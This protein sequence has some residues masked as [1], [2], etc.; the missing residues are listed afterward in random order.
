MSIEGVEESRL[1]LPRTPIKHFVYSCKDFLA[2][3][4]IAH[5]ALHVLVLSLAAEHEPEQ[6][7]GG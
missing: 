6:G 2:S 4:H 3:E 1:T 5:D 7:V